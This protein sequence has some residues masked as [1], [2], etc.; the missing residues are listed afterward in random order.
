MGNHRKGYA[1]I[2]S[3]RSLKENERMRRRENEEMG[4]WVNEE[5][6]R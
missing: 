1:R 5:M 2:P 4:R 6:G 3:N